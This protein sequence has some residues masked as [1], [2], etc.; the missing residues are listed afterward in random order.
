[1][2]L[3]ICLRPEKERHVIDYQNVGHCLYDFTSQ[4]QQTLALFGNMNIKKEVGRVAGFHGLKNVIITT[5]MILQ[6]V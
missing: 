4:H 6:N 1:M 2:G 5:S 3:I